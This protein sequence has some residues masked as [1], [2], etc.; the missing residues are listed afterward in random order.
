MGAV[1]DQFG[2]PL[3]GVRVNLSASGR[4]TV[5]NKDGGFAFGFQ[6]QAGNEIPEGRYKLTVNPEFSVSG[7][8]TQVRTI[9]LQAGRKNELGLLR[10]PELS[11][12]IPFQLINSGDSNVT[13]AG[14]D[15]RLNL[16]SAKLLFTNGRTSGSVQ[17]QFMPFEQLG[18]AIAPGAW[19]QWMFAL[20]PRGINVEGSVGIDIKMPALRGAYDY[21]PANMIY[22]V[23]LGYNSDREV[24]EP[25]GI[26][27]I[28]NYRVTSL[29]KLKIQSLDYLGYAIVKPD[30]QALLK[31]VADGKQTL[32]QLL[33][34]LQQ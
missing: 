17:A 20:Q 24:I 32:Q 4:T 14:D 6:E 12:D 19:P 3:V 15:L 34:V 31:D 28:E 21:I 26:G 22:V 29:G 8:G 30:Q 25:I 23:L 16:S 11:P 10:L 2:Q 13:L 33:S 5:T 7:Y 1:A 9:T 18:A 27:K